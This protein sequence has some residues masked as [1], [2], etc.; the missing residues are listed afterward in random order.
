MSPRASRPIT[1]SSRSAVTA[2]APSSVVTNASVSASA[3]TWICAEASQSLP[4]FVSVTSTTGF[5]VARRNVPTW[6]TAPRSWWTNPSSSFARAAVSG[7]DECVSAS[8]RSSALASP[9]S[10]NLVSP[11]L[12][13]PPFS[14][15]STAARL[16]SM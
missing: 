2:A 13:L 9:S 6:S 5:A 10:E 8:S 14:S 7:S 1:E 4:P 15:R 16:A 12:P 3:Y 11:M